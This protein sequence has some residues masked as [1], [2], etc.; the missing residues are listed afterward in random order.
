MKFE[1]K[2]NENFSSKLLVKKPRGRPWKNLVTSLKNIPSQTWRKRG[3]PRKPIYEDVFPEINTQ[4]RSRTKVESDSD[5][6]SD[7]SDYLKQTQARNRKK[8]IAKKPKNINEFESEERRTIFQ[9]QK[10]KS[11]SLKTHTK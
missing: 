9:P 7:Y 8:K 4:Q 10:T 1:E 5:S 6:D 11:T 2:L 3:R